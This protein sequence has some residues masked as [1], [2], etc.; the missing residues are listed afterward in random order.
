M[1]SVPAITMPKVGNVQPHEP[2]ATAASEK[3]NKLTSPKNLALGGLAAAF[4]VGGGVVGAMRGNPLAGLGVGA[5][6]A[7][8]TVGAALIGNASSSRRDGY[9]DFYG[10][11]DCDYPGT[12]QPPYH[13]PYYPPDYDYPRN[14]YP[15]NDYPRNDYPDPYPYGGTSPG[16]DY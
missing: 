10:D 14:D 13:E 8:V 7:G 6:L 4:L 12:Y 1:T 9:C 15:R 5:A 11:P 2:H 3:S 16:D